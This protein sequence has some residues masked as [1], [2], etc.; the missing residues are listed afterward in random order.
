MLSTKRRTCP[1]P[2]NPATLHTARPPNSSYATSAD[3]PAAPSPA[4]TS[5]AHLDDVPLE[6]LTVNAA[7][8]PP[9]SRPDKT[10]HFTT[11]ILWLYHIRSCPTRVIAQ[12]LGLHQ[13]TVRRIIRKHTPRRSGDPGRSEPTEAGR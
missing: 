9:R 11:A 1:S 2:A 7:A 6:T 4:S 10:R 8:A 3:G 13:G 12:Q 5:C